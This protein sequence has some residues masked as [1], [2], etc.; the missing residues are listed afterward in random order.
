MPTQVTITITEKPNQPEAVDI[1]ID[2]RV[3]PHYTA[4]ERKVAES[5]ANGVVKHIKANAEVEAV[6][7]LGFEPPPPAGPQLQ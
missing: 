5:I 1:A 7:D 4:F 6:V 3:N 2:L